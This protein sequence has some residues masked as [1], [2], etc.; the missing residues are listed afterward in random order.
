MPE[1]PTPNSSD[2]GQEASKPRLRLSLDKKSEGDDKASAEAPLA[3]SEKPSEPDKKSSESQPSEGSGAAPKPR[4]SLGL[5]SSKPKEDVAPATKAQPESEPAAPKKLGLGIKKTPPAEPEGKEESDEL[6]SDAFTVEAKH[7]PAKGEKPSPMKLGLKQSGTPAAEPLETKP[8]QP[9]A[10][11][12]KA[13]PA[14]KPKLTIGGA[15]PEATPPAVEPAAPKPAGGAPPLKKAGGPPS[16][17]PSQSS[18]PGPPKQAGGPKPPGSPLK[19]APAPPPGGGAAPGPPKPAGGPPSPMAK[20]PAPAKRPAAPQ[21]KEEEKPEEVAEEKKSSIVGILKALVALVMIGGLCTIGISFAL[22][23]WKSGDATE[24][25]SKGIGVIVTET[26][27]TA[28]ER[29]AEANAITDAGMDQGAAATPQLPTKPAS[30]PAIPEAVKPAAP[31]ASAVAQEA[32]PA[33]FDQS[34]IAAFVGSLNISAI[35]PPRAMINNR[36]Y[37]PNDIVNEELGLRFL[38][39][40]TQRSRLVFAD[41]QG[42]RHYKEF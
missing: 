32:G 39:I 15:K 17:A 38:G 42:K 35:R 37:R 7:P 5:K 13:E 12:S 10:A 20:P 25:E 11:E 34:Q 22:K 28:E 1:S 40:D 26:I 14:A 27:A 41:A 24:P 29:A 8:A 2:P 6:V 18:A 30:A 31:E 21:A 19:V 9:A 16:S 33:D 3:P 4:M 36:L 23:K